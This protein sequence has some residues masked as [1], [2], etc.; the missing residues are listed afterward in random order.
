MTT[1][2]MPWHLSAMAGNVGGETDQCDVLCL[3]LHG[4]APS[5]RIDESGGYGAK[6]NANKERWECLAEIPYLLDFDRPEAV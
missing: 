4:G 1:R 3:A 5:L 2:V 6:R